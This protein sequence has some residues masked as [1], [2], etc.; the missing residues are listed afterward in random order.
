MI[1]YFYRNS[2]DIVL[3]DNIRRSN[4]RVDKK[5]PMKVIR[6]GKVLDEIDYQISID[7]IMFKKSDIRDYNQIIIDDGYVLNVEYLGSR[8][9][10]AIYKI[11]N[12]IYNLDEYRRIIDF[13]FD[14]K[15]ASSAEYNSMNI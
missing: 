6:K 8:D 5:R 15:W 9:G 10:M 7:S 4:I 12:N 1:D 11:Q 3:L 2:K 13:I 14:M